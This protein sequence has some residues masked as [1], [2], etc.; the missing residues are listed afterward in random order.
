MLVAS[1]SGGIASCRGRDRR[2][3][4]RE[5]GIHAHRAEQRTLARHIRPGHQEEGSAGPQLDV[6]GH[7]RPVGQE[8]VAQ[9][10][11]LKT[12]CR[13]IDLG[14]GPAGIVVGKR[15]QRRQGLEF[16]QGPEPRPGVD[17]EL[18]L[19]RFQQAQYVKI[20]QQHDLQRQIDEDEEQ[21]R[22][23]N[24]V[25]GQDALQSS[26]APQHAPAE[27]R[28]LMLDGFQLRAG[29]RHGIHQAEHARVS[30]RFMVTQI[31]TSRRCY[32][33]AI[34]RRPRQ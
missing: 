1:A 18:L 17:A 10:A 11:G 26:H 8:R 25:E 21:R 29:V 16:T 34:P 4:L 28:C 19:P 30:G 13:F 14:H 15:C 2:P 12:L 33:S 5:D 6:V 23:A 31:D 3:G 27:V 24:P 22:V 20:V 32:G 7:A 9:F